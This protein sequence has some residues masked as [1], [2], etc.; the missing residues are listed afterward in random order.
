MLSPSGLI[1]LRPIVNNSNFEMG[2][3]KNGVPQQRTCPQ[4]CLC[5]GHN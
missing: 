1:Q 2:A 4:T 3:P 5:V